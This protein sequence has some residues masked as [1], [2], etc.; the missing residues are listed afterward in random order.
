MPMKRQPIINHQMRA[1]LVEE[2]Q[3][4]TMKEIQDRTGIAKGTL[5]AI[6]AEEGCRKNMRL[7]R[8]YLNGE[9]PDP[10]TTAR[11]LSPGGRF[12]TANQDPT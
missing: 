4:K 3:T 1:A 5:M 7:I 9:I 10:A 11:L 8:R 6:W 2:M 12:H